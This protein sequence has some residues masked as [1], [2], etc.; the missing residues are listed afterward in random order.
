MTL[1]DDKAAARKRAFAA[2][3]AAKASVDEAKAQG[4]L[5]S[6][7]HG[8]KGSVL[9]GYIPIRTEIDPVPVMSRWD[10]PVVVP[11]IEGANKPLKFAR[12]TSDMEMVNGAFDVPVPAEPE[13]LV[14]EVLIVPL[15]A[16][17][18]SGFRLGYGGGFYDRTLAMLRIS[19]HAFHAV[20]FAFEAQ[21]QDD[22]PYDERDM[23]LNA[24]ITDER[25]RVY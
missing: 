10:G 11:V 25:M 24:I 18:Q 13:F 21:R 7:L 2:R 6:A 4:F 3:K 15:V 17:S 16:F 5:E 14:P 19:G 1:A 22:L 8:R 20:G 12:W 23:P 9:A